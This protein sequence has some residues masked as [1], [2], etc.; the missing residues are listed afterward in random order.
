MKLLITGH[1]SSGESVFSFAGA[2][3]RAS[4][5]GNHEPRTT[6]GEVELPNRMTR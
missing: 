5:P 6:C 4:S 2:P 3:P 1:D